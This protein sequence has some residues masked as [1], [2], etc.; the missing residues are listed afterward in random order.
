MFAMNPVGYEKT[1][2]DSIRNQ[3]VPVEMIARLQSDYRRIDISLSKKLQI[4]QKVNLKVE[5]HSDASYPSD[6]LIL[7][8]IEPATFSGP[9]T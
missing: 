2:R 9:I 1:L 4:N 7:A 5:H 6:F 3:T 8:G